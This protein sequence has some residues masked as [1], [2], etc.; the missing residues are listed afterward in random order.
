MSCCHPRTP[1]QRPGVPRR[2]R[3]SAR[4]AI[5]GTGTIGLA[6][7]CFAAD[8]S[9]QSGKNVPI[10]MAPNAG[11]TTLGSG[12]APTNVQFTVLRGWKVQ[13]TWTAPRGA[14]Q[15]NVH[16]RLGDNDPNPQLL[17]V[18]QP[19]FIDNWGGL[20]KPGETKTYMLDLGCATCQP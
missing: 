12:P 20:L 2:R 10:V 6:L 5:V 1:Y 18:T 8:L 3:A 15:F 9:A 19:K 17:T 7:V 4:R 16:R 13:L 14:T 11:P